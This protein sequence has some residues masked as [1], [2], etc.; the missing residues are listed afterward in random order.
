MEEEQCR[1]NPPVNQQ[2]VEPSRFDG[3]A[4]Q[5]RPESPGAGAG[6]TYCASR[7]SA[8]RRPVPNGHRRPKTR[9]GI[10]STEYPMTRA[11]AG[12]V[13]RA[14]GGRRV[15]PAPDRAGSSSPA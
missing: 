13:A 8:P 1:P 12:R 7:R 2:S 11:R 5:T 10:H 3:G 6:Y 9:A 4:A 15:G 14:G